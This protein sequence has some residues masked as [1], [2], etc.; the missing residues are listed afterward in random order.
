MGLWIDNGPHKNKTA[1]TFRRAAISESQ[2]KLRQ[3][4]KIPHACAA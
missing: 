4:G 2:R 3:P 1:G